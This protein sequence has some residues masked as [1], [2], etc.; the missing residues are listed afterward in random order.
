MI[1]H[2]LAL[3]VMMLVRYRSGKWNPLHRSS[4]LSSSLE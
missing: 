3:F 1:A 2:N 4:A